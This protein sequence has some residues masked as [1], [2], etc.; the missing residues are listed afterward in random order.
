MEGISEG[1]IVH[2]VLEDGRSFGEHRGAIIV[3]NWGGPKGTVNLSVFTD[4]SND[5]DTYASGLVWKTSR[6]YDEAGAPGTWHWPE[7]V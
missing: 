6:M 7:R 2:Y 4:H 1:R 3:K 5:G